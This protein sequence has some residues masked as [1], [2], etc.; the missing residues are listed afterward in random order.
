M[1]RF[2]LH[3]SLST[4]ACVHF[5]RPGIRLSGYY[6]LYTQS[7]HLLAALCLHL[8]AAVSNLTTTP[9][10]LIVTFYSSGG[11]WPLTDGASA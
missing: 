1:L 3:L 5:S 2:H 4:I 9:T 10:V 7:T 11:Q 8:L 6:C